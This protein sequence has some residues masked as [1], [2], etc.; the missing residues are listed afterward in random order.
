MKCPP[1][2]D[3]FDH[4]DVL[5]RHHLKDQKVSEV[6]LIEIL[7]ARF[8]ERQDD[9]VVKDILGTKE[10]AE[11]FGEEELKVLENWKSNREKNKKDHSVSSG[12]L[13]AKRK[14]HAAKINDV[15]KK[16]LQSQNARAHLG[17]Q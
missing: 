7:A 16:R 9:D 14:D 2:S 13:V 17:W 5:C 11:G 15:A 4:V 12:K 3:L 6:E 10:C 8:E 1:G